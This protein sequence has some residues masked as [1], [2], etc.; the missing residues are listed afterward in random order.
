VGAAAAAAAEAASGAPPSAPAPAQAAFQGRPQD[1]DLPGNPALQDMQQQQQQQQSLEADH[2]LLPRRSLQ[3]V[4]PVFSRPTY[5][6]CTPCGPGCWTEGPGA[7]SA[8]QCS[9][10]LTNSCHSS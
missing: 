3:Q 10:C 5:N 2:Q 9:K 1:D 6:P 7:T 8:T 4:N